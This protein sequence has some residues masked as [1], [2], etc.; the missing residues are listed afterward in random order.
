MPVR[1][2]LRKGDHLVTDDLTGKVIYASQA[3]RDY[4]GNLVERKHADIIQPQLFVRGLSDPGPVA[5]FSPLTGLPPTDLFLNP[6]VGVTNV[7]APTGAATHLFSSD[8]A[9][10]NMAVGSTLVVR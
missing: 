2:R 5:I 1:K 6:N 9:I 8:L 3:T 4:N 7:P 10:P